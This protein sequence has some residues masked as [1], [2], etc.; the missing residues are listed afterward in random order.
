[1]EHRLS[2]LHRPPPGQASQTSR[3]N[4]ALA[5]TWVP[6]AVAA[7]AG[8]HSQTARLARGEGHGALAEDLHPRRRLAEHQ[9][10]L[11]RSDCSRPPLADS[12]RPLDKAA[13]DRLYRGGGQPEA[14]PSAGAPHPVEARLWHATKPPV[15]SLWQDSRPPLGDER[16]GQLAQR[17]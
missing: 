14:G 5:D 8:R 15:P 10:S 3:K 9:A 7:G 13:Q 17:P 11:V 4:Q 6:W 16:Q 1:M 12:R 2:I